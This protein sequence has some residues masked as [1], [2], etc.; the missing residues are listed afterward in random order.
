MN[1]AQLAG[2]NSSAGAVSAAGGPVPPGTMNR[3]P[4]GALNPALQSQQQAANSAAAG[5]RNIRGPI[6]DNA[7]NIEHIVRY[8]LFFTFLSLFYFDHIK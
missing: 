1:N 5:A 6:T 3:G 4:G 7:P 2:T 8:F